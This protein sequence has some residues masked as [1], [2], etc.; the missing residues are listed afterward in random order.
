MLHNQ[1]LHAVDT[2]EHVADEQYELESRVC[3]VDGEVYVVDSLAVGQAG[4]HYREEMARDRQERT[5]CAWKM[6]SKLKILDK[7]GS[8]FRFGL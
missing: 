4:K 3:R 7:C 2:L 6:V 1:V 5:K 8:N